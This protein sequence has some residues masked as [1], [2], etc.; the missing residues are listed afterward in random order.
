LNITFY[1]FPE[2]GTRLYFFL[3]LSASQAQIRFRFFFEHGF[4]RI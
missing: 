3:N 1:K 2:Y 4:A